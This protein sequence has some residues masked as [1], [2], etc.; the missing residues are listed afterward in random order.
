MN[1]QCRVLSLWFLT[2]LYPHSYA[3]DLTIPEAIPRLVLYYPRPYRD[4]LRANEGLPFLTF[5]NHP[6]VLGLAF[7]RC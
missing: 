3:Q 1:E 5:A 2:S 7:D 6:L 4:H